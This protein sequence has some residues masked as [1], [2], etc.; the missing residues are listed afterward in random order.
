MYNFHYRAAARCNKGFEVL[1]SV[2]VEHFIQVGIRIKR[3]PSHADKS[4]QNIGKLLHCQMCEEWAQIPNSRAPLGERFKINL[5]VVAVHLGV[6]MAD[7]LSF[8]AKMDM[9]DF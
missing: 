2:G 4:L 8:T 6:K 9:V 7:T 1:Y 3:G 5:T